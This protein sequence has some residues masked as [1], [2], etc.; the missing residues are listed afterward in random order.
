MINPPVPGSNAPPPFTVATPPGWWA[1]LSLRVGIW[2]LALGVLVYFASRATGGGIAG[3][4]LSALVGWGAFEFAILPVRAARRAGETLG[5]RHAFVGGC[6]TLAS[7]CGTGGI[8]FMFG[9]GMILGWIIG[10][11]V[12]VLSHRTEVIEPLRSLGL[13]AVLPAAPSAAQPASPPFQLPG[14]RW[15]LAVVGLV[16]L[17]GGL[18]FMGFGAVRSL[19]AFSV[20][21]DVCQKPCAMVHGVWLNVVPGADGSVVSRLDPQ[22]LRLQVRIR[23]DVADPNTVQRDNFTLELPPATYPPVTDRAGCPAWQ[24][25]T[26]RIDQTTGVL[27]LCFAVPESNADLNQLILD[28]RLP[29]VST[30]ISLDKAASIGVQL[31]G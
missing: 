5:P 12:A 27:A 23:D 19:E 21:T 20:L 3:I 30:Q 14:P 13:G 9:S 8:F 1:N 18:T 15:A 25:E 17:L 7:L 22:G 4:L 11:V 26:L 16:A 29:G 31:G 10:P 24:S 28:W 2:V 6:L